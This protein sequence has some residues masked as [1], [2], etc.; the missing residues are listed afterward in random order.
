M[1]IAGWILS[2]LAL[3]DPESAPN[4]APMVRVA[5]RYI[6]FFVIVSGATVGVAAQIGGPTLVIILG[7]AINLAF[8]SAI[9]QQPATGIAGAATILLGALWASRIMK[10]SVHTPEPPGPPGDV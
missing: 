4:F 8:Q 3:S 5:V 7:A 10:K 6:G 9:V 2:A 1:M